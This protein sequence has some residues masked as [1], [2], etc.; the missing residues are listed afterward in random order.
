MA[1]TV[2][3]QRDQIINPRIADKSHD[4]WTDFGFDDGE[5]GPAHKLGCLFN[6]HSWQAGIFDLHFLLINDEHGDGLLGCFHLF[7]LDGLLLL[8]LSADKI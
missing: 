2:F 1:L 3:F 7:L 4:S 8:E 5:L 6:D